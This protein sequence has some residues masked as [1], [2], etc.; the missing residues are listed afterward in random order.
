MV[1][2]NLFVGAVAALGASIAWFIWNTGDFA[3]RIIDVWRR[4]LPRRQLSWGQL[5]RAVLRSMLAHVTVSVSGRTIVPSHYTVRL[6]EADAD[7]IAAARLTFESALKAALRRKAASKKWDCAPMIEVLV[8]D[9]PHARPGAPIVEA[10]F[11][12]R[13]LRD[14]PPTQTNARASASEADAASTPTLVSADGHHISLPPDR[15]RVTIGRSSRAEF[16]LTHPTVSAIHATLHHTPSAWYLE[17][18][19][20]TNGTWINGARVVPGPMGAHILREGDVVRF[21]QTSPA[22][23][24]V[25]GED[26]P[27]K[28]ERNTRRGPKPTPWMQGNH[29]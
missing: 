15:H 27:P 6:A 10:T 18:R 17:D 7:L 21:G 16:V 23:T 11:G 2:A 28:P 19:S 9:D 22:W 5:E 24:F 12:G 25:L 3:P 20:S 13:P 4:C 29:D 26:G 8:L 14:A 1:A